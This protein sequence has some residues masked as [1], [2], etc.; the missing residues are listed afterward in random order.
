MRG[1]PLREKLHYVVDKAQ[2]GPVRIKSQ[3]WQMIYRSYQNLG[4]KLPRA[5]RDVQ[6]FNW[7]AA[8]D[9]VP[10][11]Y[12]GRV[13]LFWASSD[14]RAKLDLIAGWQLL[15]QGGMEVQEIPGT[16]L[17]IIKEPHVAELAN[18]LNESLTRAQERHLRIEK[19]PSIDSITE[20]LVVAS[21][22]ISREDSKPQAIVE[23]RHEVA[24]PSSDQALVT[25]AI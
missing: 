25:E 22:S 23:T 10:Q 16:H 5:L 24:A 20:P 19:P 1:L 6:E 11:Q 18:K 7:L 2:Y 21:G 17:N 13:T 8:R 9:Y 15:A 4:R 12:D 14:L 3:L